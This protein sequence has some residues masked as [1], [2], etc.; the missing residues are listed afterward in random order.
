MGPTQCLQRVQDSH[1]SSFS[2]GG[3]RAI[4]NSLVPGCS[5]AGFALL[6]FFL[7]LFF[8]L[9]FLLQGLVLFY[10]FFKNFI[11]VEL[12]YNVVLLQVYSKVNQLYIYLY[13]FFSHIVYYRILSRPPCALLGPC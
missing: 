5:L 12:I 10:L 3:N 9:F 13:P 8:F 11:G 4:V 7:L 6:L 1:N 2:L